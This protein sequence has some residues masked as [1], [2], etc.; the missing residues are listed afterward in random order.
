MFINSD[1]RKPYLSQPSETDSKKYKP[2]SASFK[3]PIVSPGTKVTLFFQ[4][5]LVRPNLPQNADKSNTWKESSSQDKLLIKSSHS[6]LTSLTL[7][8]KNHHKIPSPFIK[9]T[10]DIG[11]SPKKKNPENSK[12]SSSNLNSSNLS[13]LT[14]KILS[15]AKVGIQKWVSHTREVIF[16]MDLQELVKVH[17]PKPSPQKS[18]TQ[19]VLST[20]QIKSMTSLSTVSWTQHQRNQSS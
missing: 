10:K 2:S 12:V 14:L 4:L 17:S 9:T 1:A 11:I 7:E 19:S 3:E 5:K 13:S 6:S 8:I 16:F 20:V 15:K 18:S